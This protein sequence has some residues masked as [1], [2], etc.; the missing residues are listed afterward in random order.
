MSSA[1]TKCPK[2][3][4][5]SVKFR[6]FSFRVMVLGTGYSFLPQLPAQTLQSESSALA[7]DYLLRRRPIICVHCTQWAFWHWTYSWSSSTRTSCAR[8]TTSPRSS[9]RS[10]CVHA[11]SGCTTTSS[12]DEDR[13][14]SSSSSTS[15]TTQRL[16]SRRRFMIQL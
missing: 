9:T 12:D 14:S 10:A 8:V 7:C 11:P 16:P 15:F 5:F 13:S 1:G 2:I 6:Q 4:I 3:H